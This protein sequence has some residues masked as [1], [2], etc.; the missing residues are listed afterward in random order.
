MEKAW[1]KKSIGNEKQAAQEKA[2]IEVKI[3]LSR[4]SRY[5]YALEYR[6]LNTARI[7]VMISIMECMLCRMLSSWTFDSVLASPCTYSFIKFK[8]SELSFSPRNSLREV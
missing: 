5:T 4:A 8:N 7:I 3:Y 1:Q 2:R 6:S